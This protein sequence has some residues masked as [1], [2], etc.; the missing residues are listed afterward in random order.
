MVTDPQGAIIA[1]GRG[2]RLRAGGASLPKPLVELDGTPLL[3]RQVRQLLAAG[4]SR[5][6]AVINSETAGLIE[7]RRIALP[8]ELDLVV[9]DTPNSMESLFALGERLRPGRFLMATVDSVPARGGFDSFAREALAATAPGGGFDGALGLVRWRGD[10]GPLFAEVASDGAITALGA[11]ESALVTAGL[12]LFSTRI[13]DFVAPARAAKL[14]A[15]REFLAMLVERGLRLRAVTI[16][17]A[18]DVDELADLESARA[19]LASER[20]AGGR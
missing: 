20:A 8:P 17:G 7:A 12:Y 18:I 9:R 14:S 15:L 19:M 1:A 3:V 5:V 11:R 16:A 10:H 13:F 6:A 2:E 4:A